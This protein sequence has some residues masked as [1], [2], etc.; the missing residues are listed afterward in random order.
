M[1]NNNYKEIKDM[2]GKIM[3]AIGA[4]DACLIILN[5]ILYFTNIYNG[6]KYLPIMLVIL[7]VTANIKK[8]VEK[9]ERQE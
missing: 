6:A 4:I 2:L 1:A 9:K 8:I 3:F 7:C 5:A